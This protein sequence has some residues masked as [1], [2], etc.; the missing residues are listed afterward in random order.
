MAQVGHK[1]ANHMFLPCLVK[2]PIPFS[3]LS[4]VV[5]FEDLQALKTFML[6]SGDVEAI[7]VHHLGP[8]RH[9]VLDKLILRVRTSVDLS[10][11]PELGVR[12]ED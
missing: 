3:S 10:Q 11:S 1:V 12:T 4:K 9:E 5:C 2:R 6:Q 8:G 7:K